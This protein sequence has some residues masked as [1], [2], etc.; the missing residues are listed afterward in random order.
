VTLR[1]EEANYALLTRPGAPWR[2][3]SFTS[4]RHKS[5]P[6]SGR[7]RC[8]PAI[9]PLNGFRIAVPRFDPK[10]LARGHAVQFR[11]QPAGVEGLRIDIIT[12]LRGVPAFDYLWSGER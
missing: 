6:S 12:K 7:N 1:V 5:E 9:S 8:S 2:G 3:S 10:I 11:C 4:R